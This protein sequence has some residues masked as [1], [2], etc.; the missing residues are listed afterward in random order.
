MQRSWTPCSLRT[1]DSLWTWP[2]GRKSTLL[3]RES[4]QWWQK[5]WFLGHLGLPQQDLAL[6]PLPRNL[7]GTQ[8][9]SSWRWL[10]SSPYHKLE[11]LEWRKEKLRAI[12]SNDRNVKS[13]QHALADS[14]HSGPRYKHLP[15]TSQPT[16]LNYFHFKH[17]RYARIFTFL[18]NFVVI[19]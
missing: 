7:C 4:W 14:H 2:L 3:K 9:T 6:N 17:Q 5:L 15:V 18:P 8:G 11:D 19:S 16:N 12:T 10:L 1:D 13:S